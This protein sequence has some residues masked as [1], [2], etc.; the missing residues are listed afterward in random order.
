MYGVLRD[1]TNTGN[2]AELIAVF[3]APL[4]VRSNKPAFASDTYSLKRRVGGQVAQRWEVEASMAPTNNTAEFMV[5]LVLNGYTEIFKIRMP[6]VVVPDSLKMPISRNIK[7]AT[8]HLAMQSFIHITGGLSSRFMPGAFIRFANHPKVYMVA[9]AQPDGTGIDI[10][11][12]L[13]R[14]VPKD[15]EII[16]GDKVSLDV[17]YDTDTHLGI[18]YVDG[19]LTDLGTVRFIEAL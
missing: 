3:A 17:R 6:Q 12:A 8:S 9:S 16:F 1:S 18:K 4:N 15:T 2:D 10:H 11:P 14:N 5:N 19:I 13:L 7:T